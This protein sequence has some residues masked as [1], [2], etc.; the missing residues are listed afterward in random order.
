MF[1]YL[2]GLTQNL[3]HDVGFFHTRELLIQPLE[4]ES[5]QR[6]INAKLMEDGGIQVADVD[7]VVLKTGLGRMLVVQ[8]RDQVQH[9]VPDDVCLPSVQVQKPPDKWKQ[10]TVSSTLGP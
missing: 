3:G 7:R 10:Q 9:L 6:V 4:G 2:F 1:V 5:K 8:L